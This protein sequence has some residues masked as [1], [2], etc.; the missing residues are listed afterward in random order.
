MNLVTYQKLKK[1]NIGHA[2]LKIDEVT[3]KENMI[4]DRCIHKVRS[5]QGL[6]V[7]HQSRL[8]FSIKLKL[9]Q[10]KIFD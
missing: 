2:K 7:P 6:N 4:N 10:K 5:I 1:K 3:V 8:P 9:E